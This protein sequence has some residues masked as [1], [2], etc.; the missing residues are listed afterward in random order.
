M[1]R[2]TLNIYVFV[3]FL[4]IRVS[5]STPEIWILGCNFKFKVVWCAPFWPSHQTSKRN[6][7][8]VKMIKYSYKN[9][10][11]RP[12]L[13]HDRSGPE[14]M[15]LIAIY[16]VLIQHTINIWVHWYCQSNHQICR[17]TELQPV[18][19]GRFLRRQFYLFIALRCRWL[20]EVGREIIGGAVA[21]WTFWYAFRLLVSLRGCFWM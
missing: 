10:I 12:Q 3:P 14:K 9:D 19:L 4:N 7:I 1:I 11:H 17:C 8:N 20:G 13:Q 5:F 15:S 2:D 21:R 16:F 6:Y 18:A